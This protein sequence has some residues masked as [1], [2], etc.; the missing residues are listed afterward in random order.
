MITVLAAIGEPRA[1]IGMTHDTRRWVVVAV[2][3]SALRAMPVNSTRPSGS[4]VAWTGVAYQPSAVRSVVDE[5]QASTTDGSD[6]TAAPANRALDP[7]VAAVEPD[8]APGTWSGS[9]QKNAP[10]SASSPS[11]G[12]A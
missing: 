12:L 4:S 2:G 11:N 9:V 8:G 1:W 5:V 3:G 7:E 6:A 10:Q